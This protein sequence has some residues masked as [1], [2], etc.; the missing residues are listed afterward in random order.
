MSNKKVSK[1]RSMVGFATRGES[2]P[3]GK[4]FEPRTFMASK[5]D[6]VK[7]YSDL[8]ATS[9]FEFGQVLPDHVKKGDVIVA[10]LPHEIPWISRDGT[11]ALKRA[12][13]LDG[14]YITAQRHVRD[15]PV[16]NML[17]NKGLAPYH[18]YLST[19]NINNL[20]AARLVPDNRTK[21]TVTG[22]ADPY[23]RPVADADGFQLK[24]STNYTLAFDYNTMPN[25]MLKLRNIGA[26]SAPI[27]ITYYQGVGRAVYNFTTE[28]A[29]RQYLSID[30]CREKSNSNTTSSYGDWFELNNIILV[31]GTYSELPFYPSTYDYGVVHGNVQLNRGSMNPWQSAR[32]SGWAYGT[33]TV[34]LADLGLKAG[35]KLTLAIDLDN[36]KG[37]NLD[38]VRCSIVTTKDGV[39]EEAFRGQLIPVGAKG[40]SICTATISSTATGLR[41][42]YITKTTSTNSAEVNY[43][44]LRLYKGTTAMD[45]G[46]KPTQDQSGLTIVNSGMVPLRPDE[47]PLAN[48]AAG[49][50]IAR[51]KAVG[52]SANIEMKVNIVQMFVD[53]YPQLFEL[54]NTMAKRIARFKTYIKS[55]TTITTFRG[56]GADVLTGII[57]RKYSRL[58][59]SYNSGTTWQDT[60]S[61]NQTDMFNTYSNSAYTSTIWNS[62]DADGN[63]PFKVSTLSAGKNSGAVAGNDTPAL[64]E[65]RDFQVII[66]T[67]QTPR[68]NY[69]ETM[70]GLYVGKVAQVIRDK[71]NK[72]TTVTAMQWQTLADIPIAVTKNYGAAGSYTSAEYHL[73]RIFTRWIQPATQWES[74]YWDENNADWISNNTF[75]LNAALDTPALG[76]HT[77]W[78]YQPQGEWSYTNFVDY[79]EN[80][81]NKYGVFWKL[82]GIVLE[83]LGGG[84]LARKIRH[85]FQRTAMWRRTIPDWL[86]DVFDYKVTQRETEDSSDANVL[87]LVDETKATKPTSDK[88]PYYYSYVLKKGGTIARNRYLGI[89]PA[90]EME[91]PVRITTQKLDTEENALPIDQ[92]ATAYLAGNG[93]FRHDIELKI[94]YSGFALDL[95][96]MD[97]G[98]DFDLMIDGMTYPTRLTA[99]R[100]NSEDDYATLKFGTSRIKLKSN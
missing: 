34:S 55:M 30:P 81:F 36:T 1:M 50:V 8:R 57:P 26:A 52:E 15:L 4:P 33:L 74:G 10:K 7:D 45:D 59:F 49:D 11:T 2:F 53:E 5:Y 9:S 46:W 99:I 68:K 37:T 90:G 69:S 40:T 77:A 39:D 76:S 73:T 21:F 60:G 12:A 87:N 28:A 25:V 61:L 64:L 93:L 100:M 32:F 48:A 70:I 97:L 20:H 94:Y 83:D 88:S 51:N 56:I 54:D 75:L 85:I 18:F 17:I 91:L 31:E 95:R 82:Q 35:D 67:N 66:E 92:Q 65:L 84:Q 72:R 23:Y 62:I 89:P 44:R 80:M 22:N 96:T 86:P 58:M 78:A 41:Y 27:E 71:E 63:Y 24:K 14:K 16:S 47:Y 98:D 29:G 42:N 3:A 19:S 38:E 6:V 13:A 43:A 79:V